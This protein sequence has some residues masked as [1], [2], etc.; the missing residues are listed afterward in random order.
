M[1]EFRSYNRFVHVRAV[2]AYGGVELRLH[3]FLTSALD[4]VS[5]QL[6]SQEEESTPCKVPRACFGHGGTGTE[7][8]S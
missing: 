2:E 7:V 6:Y 4:A 3:S 1:Y 5:V 8:L